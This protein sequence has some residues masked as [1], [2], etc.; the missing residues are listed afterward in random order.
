MNQLRLHVSCPLTNSLKHYSVPPLDFLRRRTFSQLTCIFLMR[1][2]CGQAARIS[3]D[4]VAAAVALTND[5]IKD[6]NAVEATSKAA[7]S[8]WRSSQARLPAQTLTT[9]R[10]T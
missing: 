6:G 10:V 4:A 8:A 2:H 9:R 5:C 1:V 3:A 7:A